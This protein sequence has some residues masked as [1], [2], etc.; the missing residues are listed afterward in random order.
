VELVPR[1]PFKNLKCPAELHPNVL[2]PGRAHTKLSTP[3]MHET[4]SRM[5]TNLGF[6]LVCTNGHPHIFES[7]LDSSDI[8]ISYDGSAFNRQCCGYASRLSRRHTGREI[9]RSS[10]RDVIV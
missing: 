6:E 3:R 8:N 7:L 2:D 4:T 5:P 9:S 10:V 1:W